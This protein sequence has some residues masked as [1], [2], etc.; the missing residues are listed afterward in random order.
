M[1]SKTSLLSK[2]S[3]GLDECARI[4]KKKKLKERDCNL[5][6]QVQI[7][8]QSD[9]KWILQRQH[10]TMNNPGQLSVK[11]TLLVRTNVRG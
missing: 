11:I 3:L 10:E 2:W 9:A 6:I 7:L 8:L 5:W 1:P 4:K